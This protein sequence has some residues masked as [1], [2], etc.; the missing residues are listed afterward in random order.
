MFHEVSVTLVTPEDTMIVVK[1]DFVSSE[2]EICF[3]AGEIQITE[4]GIDEYLTTTI[5]EK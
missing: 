1:Y 2:N 3:S 4:M 5:A